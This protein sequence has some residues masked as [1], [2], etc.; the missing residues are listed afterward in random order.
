MSTHSVHVSHT[1]FSFILEALPSRNY[2]THCI[3]MGKNS[4]KVTDLDEMGWEPETGS[5]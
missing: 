2:D 5:F 1:S 3:K 4:S